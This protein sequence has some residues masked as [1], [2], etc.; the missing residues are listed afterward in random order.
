M[1][2]LARGSGVV[3]VLMLASLVI[4][5]VVAAA[6]SM[7]RFGFGFLT[8]ASWQP[9]ERQVPRLDAHGKAV[10][11]EDGEIVMDTIPPSFGALPMIYGTVVSSV[12]ALVLAAPLSL[13]A[14]LFLVRIAPRVIVGP[15]S[16]LIEFLAAIPSLAYGI[17]GL[18]V[19]APFLRNHVEP[20]AFHALGGVWG[21]GW[22]FYDHEGRR[23][24]LTGLDM[25]CGGLILGIMIIPIITA[26][27]R[28][29]LASVPRA[30]LEGT[31]ALGAT[32]W[33]SALEMMEFG[34]SGLFGAIILGLARAAGETMAVTMVIGNNPRIALSVFA[35]AQTMSSLLASKFQEAEDL[36][37][38]ALLEIALILLVMSLLFNVTAR[39][40][41]VGK[42]S[43]GAAAH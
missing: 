18:C 37:R 36:D 31:V 12:L 41:V 20:A 13:G 17:W 26:I 19:L 42:D 23:H 9:N 35:R 22:L 4:V 5:L 15:I 1:R 29:I 8:T 38:S 32:W 30:Q 40:L 10:R 7:K 14:A 6:P 27:S 3:I 28:D 2:G 39:W 43:H 24:L 25:L 16:F 11:D 33:Q 34:R 21:F